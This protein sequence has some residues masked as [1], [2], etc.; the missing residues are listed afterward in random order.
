MSFRLAAR[1]LISYGRLL[2]DIDPPGK[3]LPIYR[4]DHYRSNE[5]RYVEVE[6]F[7]SDTVVEY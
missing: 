2:V 6:R 1:N 7:L 5:P 3:N 4:R